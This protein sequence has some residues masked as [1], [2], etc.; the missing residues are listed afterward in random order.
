MPMTLEKN[1]WEIL[2][3]SPYSDIKEIR[4]AYRKKLLRYHPDIKG[5]KKKYIDEYL[6]ILKAYKKIKKLTE[7]IHPVKILIHSTTRDIN[8]DKNPNGLFIFLELSAKEAF[9]G[10][11]KLIIINQAYR[12]CNNCKGEGF[13]WT[14]K[15]C[16]TCKGNGYYSVKWGDEYI[17]LICQRCKGTGKHRVT[18]QKCKGTGKTQTHQ[19]IL[20]AIPK[21]L[22]NSSIL[23]YELTQQSTDDINNSCLYIE[24][25]VALPPKWDIKGL[26]IYAPL[27]IDIWTALKGDTIPIPT[28]EGTILINITPDDIRSGQLII[29]NKGWRDPN[30]N[31]GDHIAKLTLILPEGPI[32]PEANNIIDILK[33][34]W[35]VKNNKLLKALPYNKI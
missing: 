25:G 24:V 13:I 34:I 32:P 11:T 16:A 6:E 26:D 17:Q 7:P 21:G 5:N 1:P 12:K 19:K 18:C 15:E 9:N 22:T 35:P 2:G 27:D 14:H 20:I 29:K 33:D 3:I 28:I 31:R 8:Q 4:K 10:T 23:K 30:G